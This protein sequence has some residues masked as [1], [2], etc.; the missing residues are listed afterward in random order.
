MYL[1]LQ[2]IRARRETRKRALEKQLEKVK[3][4]L[5][6]MG[7][8]KIIIFG[9]F[10]RKN[11]RSDSDLDVVAVMPSNMSG[12]EWMRRIYDEADRDV[13]CDIL[14]FTNDELEKAIPVST[15]IRYALQTGKVVYEKGSCSP[16]RGVRGQA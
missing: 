10:A 12:K 3:R 5:I 8:L 14:A 4:L 15:F 11:V 6:G 1:T 13:D 9:S 2:E 16:R 7:A